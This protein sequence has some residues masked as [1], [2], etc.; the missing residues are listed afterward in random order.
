MNVCAINLQ[1]PTHE[2]FV[3]DFFSFQHSHCFKISVHFGL[4]LLLHL[5]RSL[6]F[7]DSLTSLQSTEENKRS[8]MMK[9][10][11]KRCMC[12]VGGRSASRPSNGKS[13]QTQ[14]CYKNHIKILS[15]FELLGMCY[16]LFN[17][18]YSF[19]CFL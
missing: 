3:R 6:A 14:G 11:C 17:C 7:C 10:I 5:R 13:N 18:H 15:S 2:F 12:G 9:K 19:Y 4:L 16:D 1:T 8:G